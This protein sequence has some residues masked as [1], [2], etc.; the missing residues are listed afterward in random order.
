MPLEV[1]Y[2]AC[3]V[4]A[5][6]RSVAGNVSRENGAQAPLHTLFGQI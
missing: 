1:T 4:R 5:H 3:L 2:C 6:Q